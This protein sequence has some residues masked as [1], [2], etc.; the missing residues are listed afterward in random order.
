MSA[1]RTLHRRSRATD[2]RGSAAAE[3]VFMTP[4]LMA[5]IAAFSIAAQVLTTR[6]ELNDVARVALEAAAAAPSP[7]AAISWAAG[8]ATSDA[9]SQS[10][11]CSLLE[12]KT[13]V[14]DFQPG[15][16]VSVTVSCL[17]HLGGFAFGPGASDIRLSASGQAAVEPYRVV[18][19]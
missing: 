12:V 9:R 10:L 18:G 16:E 8:T 7:A 1:P 19:P 13:D 17:L 15:G 6:L 11:R 4:V 14:G 5:V 2:E 3:L